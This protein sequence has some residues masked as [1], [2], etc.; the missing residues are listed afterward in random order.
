MMDGD[1]PEDLWIGFSNLANKGYRWTDGSIVRYTDW[2]KG[3]PI[4]SEYMVR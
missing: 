3:Q 1:N 2:A 4:R